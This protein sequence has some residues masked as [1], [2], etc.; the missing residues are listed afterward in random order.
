M[1]QKHKSFLIVNN[2]W[3]LF[4][5]FNLMI[6]GPINQN[7]NTWLDSAYHRPSYI[8][9][10]KF[11]WIL[12]VLLDLVYLRK[13]KTKI[14]PRQ[15]IYSMSSWSLRKDFKIW[16]KI[17]WQPQKNI[18]KNQSI[19]LLYGKLFLLVL[20]VRISTKLNIFNQGKTWRIAIR[21]TNITRR[22]GM[23]AN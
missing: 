9:S 7:H 23:T 18:K 10:W 22:C 20:N 6:T 19:C 4:F 8:E 21:Y 5:S 11:S 16:T 1:I 13:S 14:W 15:H 12:I 17:T 2:C 3:Y